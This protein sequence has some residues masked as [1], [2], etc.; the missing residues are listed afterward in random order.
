MCFYTQNQISYF[1]SQITILIIVSSDGGLDNIAITLGG[2]WDGVQPKDDIEHWNNHP[3]IVGAVSVEP[4]RVSHNIWEK[5]A[6]KG[7][8]ALPQSQPV[9]SQ[10]CN[11]DNDCDDLNSCTIAVC[12]ENLCMIS[13]TLDNCCGNGVCEPG[14]GGLAL[15][16]DCGPFS[17]RA[18]KF[19]E[20]CHTLDGFMIDAGLSSQ[21]ERIVS[22][23]SI[24]VGFS[25]PASGSLGAT[26]DLYTTKEGSYIGKE[27]SIDDWILLTTVTVEK[28][29]PKRTPG[30]VAIDL[31]NS[32]PLNVGSRR[33][34]YFA[35]SENIL[36]FGEGVYSVD[37]EDG[38]QLHSSL[39]VS[40]LF[41]NGIDGFSLIC[42]VSYSL[43][44][45]S[46]TVDSI[47]MASPPL[48]LERPEWPDRSIDSRP[49][50]NGP[51]VISS[52]ITLQ[53]ISTSLP[54]TNL[55]IEESNTGQSSEE[56][57]AS[58][59]PLSSTD[60]TTLIGQYQSADDNNM[61]VSSKATADF[62]S[63]G[64]NPQN[65]TLLYWHVA[66]IAAMYMS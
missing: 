18:P 16:S 42:E 52:P 44:D 29:N 24:S 14:E 30:I 26:I 59:S 12:E 63:A 49:P 65:L 1:S 57:T 35:A 58:T 50:S 2:L 41:G 66:L 23:K 43:D 5:L 31:P 36:K 40:G 21:A 61:Q 62:A 33:G 55:I 46:S 54:L 13:K 7:E 56:S 3:D 48:E 34:F 64:C 4:R 38:I 47:P 25:S 32:I 51:V 39:A 11:D 6:S 17:I 20:E 53:P 19:C 37:N 22:I 45:G 28:Y 27:Q 15:C 9:S 8:C 10:G 60:E